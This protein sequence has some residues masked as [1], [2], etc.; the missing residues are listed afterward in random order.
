[1]RTYTCSGTRA[2]GSVRKEAAAAADD[3]LSSGQ[4][5]KRIMERTGA[6]LE[7][8]ELAIYGNLPEADDAGEAA[9]SVG[10]NIGLPAPE[11]YP[12]V[13]PFC[14]VGTGFK[15]EQLAAWR[16]QLMPHLVR[17]DHQKPPAH[18]KRWTAKVDDRPHHWIPLDKT[19]VFEVNFG[20]IISTDQFT[21]GL[22]L[23][24]PRLHKL[25][26]D[27]P[28]FQC[29]TVADVREFKD[30]GS[31]PRA[32][33]KRAAHEFEKAEAKASKQHKP[34]TAKP[35]PTPIR[36]MVQT[37]FT[38]VLCG[39]TSSLFAGTTFSVLPCAT[40]G[41]FDMGVGGAID[42]AGV[43]R[44]LVRHG[45][46]ISITP[47]GITTHV[48][49]AK[50][51]ITT[52]VK[53]LVRAGLHD[54]LSIEWVVRCIEGQE[55][56]A[57][58]LQEFIGHA[59]KCVDERQKS[60]GRDTLATFDR[61]GDEYAVDRSVEDLSR[62]FSAVER[63]GA[64][65]S[66]GSLADAMARTDVMEDDGLYSLLGDLQAENGALQAR[67]DHMRMQCD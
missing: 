6:D 19:L 26:T 27:K 43:E 25:R 18:L 48:I 44:E 13:F 28:W 2:H 65:E 58:A 61:F 23:R 29:E 38:G 14:K 55:V 57:P 59:E 5:I 66:V 52:K 16:K 50:D 51:P 37:D 56:L 47:C 4:A 64:A 15:M 63:A 8:A 1:M 24:F 35:L 20:E 45:A 12:N 9:D 60:G 11:H 53:N 3:A 62:V 39:E 32:A 17:F 10:G 42:R 36:S 41:H 31:N 7:T 46:S 30:T 34:A 22:T 21:G 33:E 49:A 54:I 67:L 40:D